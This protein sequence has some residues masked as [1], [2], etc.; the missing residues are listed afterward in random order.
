MWKVDLDFL[1]WHRVKKLEVIGGRYEEEVDS[2]SKLD[3]T[4][5]GLRQTVDGMGCYWNHRVPR[6]C[7]NPTRVWLGTGLFQ[8]SGLDIYN[9]CTVFVL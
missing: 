1:L 2:G 6:H 9:R 5:Y 8:R 3:K 4:C 7:R